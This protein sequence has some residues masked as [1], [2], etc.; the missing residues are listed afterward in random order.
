M[1][2][3]S[4]HDFAAILSRNRSRLVR[5]CRIYAYNR[6]DQEDLFQDITYQ[7][8]RSMGNFKGNAQ[9]DTYLY[10][11]ALN[12]AMVYKT[13]Q[14]RRKP[15][16]DV[17]KTMGPSYEMHLDESLDKDNKLAW[18]YTAIR[19]LKPVEQS[20]ILLY[21]DELSYEEMAKITGLTVNNVG[22]KLNRIKKK[23]SEKVKQAN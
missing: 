1:T 8:W 18:L 5:I 21:L 15:T 10:R 2:I 19:K 7:I 22:V 4:E 17:D 13:K 3:P 6:E 20:L 16:V 14:K 12:T 11:I 23:L 9:I